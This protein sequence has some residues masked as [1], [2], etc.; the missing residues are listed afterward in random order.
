MGRR[1][2]AADVCAAT[3]YT[4]DELHALLRAMPPYSATR[5]SARVA[6]EFTPRDL[7]LLG[8]TQQLEQ[9]YGL[10]RSA[11]ALLGTQLHDALGGPK[12]VNR[13]LRLLINVQPPQVELL[14]DSVNIVDGLVIALAPIME[15]VDDYL[16]FEPQ[17]S[18]HFGPTLVARKYG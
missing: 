3:G 9:R 2:T 6:R 16:S 1:L 12:V 7:L 14:E 15:R 5:Q 10:K 11:V 8:V 18:L 13:T 17:M 4:R